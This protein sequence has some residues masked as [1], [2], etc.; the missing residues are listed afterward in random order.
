MC[1]KF[2]VRP[3]EAL[4]IKDEYT[5]YCLDEAAAFLLMQATKPDY[6]KRTPINRNKKA[7]ESLKRYGAKVQL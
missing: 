7:L 5:A 3:S 4:R 2:S 6:R 1:E